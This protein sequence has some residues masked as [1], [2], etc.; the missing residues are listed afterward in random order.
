MRWKWSGRACFAVIAAISLH[1]CSSCQ[2]PPPRPKFCPG[3]EFSPTPPG[4]WDFPDCR[5]N[6]CGN[7]GAWLGQKFK[8]RELHL[9]MGV[10][11]KQKLSI[12][13][14]RHGNEALKLDVEG[15]DLVGIR[16][17]NTK[18]KGASLK[19]ATLSIK[20]SDDS[21]TLTIEDVLE[22]PFWAGCMA[23]DRCKDA[24]PTVPVYR[25]SVIR[26]R[27]GCKVELCRPELSDDHDTLKGTAVIFKGDVYDD[28]YRVRSNDSS[29]PA[30]RLKPGEDDLFNIACVGTTVS[31][32]H[33]LR[34]TSASVEPPV[35][36][37]TVAQRQ[38]MLR[39]LTA[40]YCGIGQPF[41]EEGLPIKLGFDSPMWDVSS[42]KLGDAKSMDARWSKDGATCIGIP[43]LRDRVKS[44]TGAAV[45]DP[46]KYLLDQ[47]KQYC[48]VTNRCPAVAPAALAA[49]SVFGG[50]YGVS[51][52]LFQ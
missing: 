40:D 26:D 45:A 19:G 27:G 36:R 25:F 5:P 24:P 6:G 32:L 21:Y 52:N 51:G 44:P 1:A 14:F 30:E 37:A 13:S 11:N 33:F 2:K 8:F 28:N 34:H 49:P 10:P 38:T 35:L 47:I 41:T 20:E 9:T 43:R 39:L 31:K 17:D 7:N 18:V 12:Q 48:P 50:S 29:V 3:T 22:T 15:D 23:G 46:E 42:Y 4:V 16:N